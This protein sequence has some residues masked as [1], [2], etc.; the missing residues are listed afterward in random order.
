[1]EEQLAPFVRRPN[2]AMKSRASTHR[3]CH[4]SGEIGV[5]VP[6]FPTPGHLCSQAKFS[7]GDQLIGRKDQ[8]NGPPGTATTT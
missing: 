2:A 1:M 6:L 7:P 3:R 8:G 4:Y 5:D